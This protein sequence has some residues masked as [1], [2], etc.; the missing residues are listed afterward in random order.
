MGE[1]FFSR[2]LGGKKLRGTCFFHLHAPPLSQFYRPL[3]RLRTVT[4]SFPDQKS[5][6]QKVQPC[7]A[8]LGGHGR[9]HSN[10]CSE[11]DGRYY[12]ASPKSASLEWC[13]KRHQEFL[14]NVQLSSGLIWVQ[15]SSSVRWHSLMLCNAAR[16][17]GHDNVWMVTPPFNAHLVKSNWLPRR[18]G[19]NSY[20][21]GLYLCSRLAPYGRHG[22]T[23]FTHLCIYTRIL[24]GDD[25]AFWVL[26]HIFSDWDVSGAILWRWGLNG[27]SLKY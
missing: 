11:R 8:R 10:L 16:A 24:N 14:S 23:G 20:P 19:H 12:S 2:P 4:E 27:N 6:A 7:L 25:L 21:V 3:T 13:Q 1:P 26:E 5:E 17:A 18:S 9:G 22:K 15:G